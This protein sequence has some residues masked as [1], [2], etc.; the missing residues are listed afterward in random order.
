VVGVVTEIADSSHLPRERLR[1]IQAVID[2]SPLLPSDLLALARWIADYYQAP[3]GEVFALCLPP[4]MRRGQ[5]AIPPAGER[6][7]TLSAA[8]RQM[9]PDS[10]TRAPARRRALETLGAASAPLTAQALS[11]AGVRP[12]ILRGLLKAGLVEVGERDP[13]A[14]DPSTRDLEAAPEPTAE[15]RSAAAAILDASGGFAA[16]LLDGVT[17]SGKTEVYFRVMQRVLDAG[18]QVLLLVPEIGLTP[19][20]LA[21]LRA[22][23]AVPLAVLHSGLGATARLRAWEAAAAGAAR[24]I[25]GTRSAVLAPAPE[26]GLVIVD[27]EHDESYKQQDGVRYSARDVAVKRAAERAVPV[28]LGSATPSLE[29]LH[30]AE[31]GRYRRLVLS[32]RAGGAVTPTH[33]LIDLRRHACTGALAD[34]ALD[35]MEAR[36]AAGEQVLVFLNR[37]GYA[38]VFMCHGCGW[39]AECPRCD[40]RLT[41]HQN[42][43][44]LQCHHCG[45]REAPPSRCPAC[46]DPEPM[47]MG[48]GTQRTEVTLT[49]RFPEVPVLR[50]DRD[51][52]RSGARMARLFDQAQRGEPAILLGTQMLTKGHHFPAVTLVVVVDADAGLFSTDFRAGERLAQQLVQVAGRAGRADRPGTVLIQTRHPDDPRLTALIEQGYGAFAAQVLAERRELGLPPFGRLALL[53]AEALV[54]ADLFAFL[55]EAAAVLGQTATGVLVLGPVPAPMMRRAGRFR[56]QLLLQA[57]RRAPLHACVQRALPELDALR[58]GRR[59]RWSL[60]VDPLDMF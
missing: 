33:R 55:E 9:D 49:T 19:Q 32:E 18:R 43:A 23:F 42:P 46:G 1:P 14:P 58:S 59:I 35:A 30:N 56:G 36:F 44:A 12:E 29:S 16:F 39:I 51:A 45:R 47:P 60:D 38:P 8:G 3:P 6:V 31:T 26:L 20:T 21:R 53:R 34:A 24:I 17:G 10:L 11:A 25:V 4:A 52:V 41:L 22:R 13:D 28:L 5:A 15:Q 2:A 48:A 40:A 57:P 27:E 37:R 50:I 54:E 7:W